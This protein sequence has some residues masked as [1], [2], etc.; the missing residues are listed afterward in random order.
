MRTIPATCLAL[1]IGVTPAWAQNPL[2]RF[3]VGASTA[4]D[5]GSRGLIPAGAVPSAGALFGV[6]I[7]DAWSVEA[8]VERGF[9][10]T[11]RTDEAVWL[12]FAPANSTGAEIERLGIRARFERTQTAGPGF[13]AH[14]VWR[15]RDAGRINVG[16]LVGV[17]ARAY[18]SRVVRTTVFVPPELNFSPDHADVRRSDQTRNMTGGGP[19][20][21][22][23]VFVRLTPA[24]TVA[25]ELRY[26]HGI[27]TDDPY[28]VFRT[29]VRLMW[30]F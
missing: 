18:D 12:S 26:T 7:T 25:P 8:E 2:P 1:V 13:A 4:V 17:S 3:Y 6:R 10:T 14:A 16:L 20:G 30:S 29:G 27:I 28:R 5:G 9:H 15:S 22:V 19:S 21:G 11:G 24:L 23:V